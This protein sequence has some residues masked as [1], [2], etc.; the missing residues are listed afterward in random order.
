MRFD[1]KVLKEQSYGIIP[2]RIPQTGREALVIQHASGYWGFPK[3]HA[4]GEESACEA[5]ERELLEET[6]L[7]V[8]RY[9]SEETIDEH[10]TYEFSG[11]VHHK[12]V[13][14]FL[15]EVTGT[16]QC[17]EI[18]V[19]TAKWF[20]LDRVAK[21]LTYPELKKLYRRA[22]KTLGWEENRDATT[23]RS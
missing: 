17:Q 7:S 22:L 5:A 10:Y 8:V 12:T 21:K 11:Q 14:Y 19:R 3:G 18:E 4:D 2:F 23:T 9:L 16:V 13:T 20:P 6:N 1:Q 15:A